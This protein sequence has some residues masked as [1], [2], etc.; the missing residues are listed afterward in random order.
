[1]LTCSKQWITGHLVPLCSS[2]STCYR[3]EPLGISGTGFYLP[4]VLPVTQPTVSEHWRKHKPLTLTSGLASSVLRP[5]LG[6]WREGVLLPLHKL[7]NAVQYLYN[8]AQNSSNI[9]SRII[10][11]IMIA[12]TLYLRRW[13]SQFDGLS[14]TIW[15]VMCE[16]KTTTALVYHESCQCELADVERRRWLPP[17]FHSWGRPPP[18]SQCLQLQPSF[19]HHT[20]HSNSNNC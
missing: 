12:Q 19:H 17:Q 3:T 18:T 16:N 20:H 14:D 10:Q 15:L 8:I 2:S 1:M 6:S 11:T 4:D 9:F 5:P 13:R 7:S